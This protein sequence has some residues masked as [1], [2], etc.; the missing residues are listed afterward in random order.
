MFH[1]HATKV[2][3]FFIISIFIFNFEEKKKNCRRVRSINI[4]F[5]LWNSISTT[6]SMWFL[7]QSAVECLVQ[8]A[9]IRC[10]RRCRNLVASSNGSVQCLSTGRQISSLEWATIHEKEE[11]FEV[12][13]FKDQKSLAWLYVSIWSFQ[14]HLCAYSQNDHVFVRSN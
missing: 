11:S 2:S 1:D 10:H 7:S 12:K 14:W 6:G 4:S 5:A 9:L 8:L 3:S 13:S